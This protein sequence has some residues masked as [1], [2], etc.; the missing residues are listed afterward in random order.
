[1]EDRNFRKKQEGGFALLLTVIVVAVLISIS[2]S[3]LDV[4]IKQV[5]LAGNAKDSEIA[6]QASSAGMECGRH[7]RR[8]LSDEMTTGQTI[9]PSCFDVSTYYSNVDNLRVPSTP[10]ITGNGDVFRY[11]YAFTWGTGLDTRCTEVVTLVASSSP[12]SAVNLV[13]A[14]S[15]MYSI[16]SGWV[17]GDRICEPG[18]QC[19]VLSVRGY[20]KSC[21]NI[22]TYGTVQREVLLQY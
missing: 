10:Q 16:F 20:N 13:V 1:M 21:S 6:F 2:L 11:D 12:S 17:G 8:A 3:I 9:N 15:L 14:E 22:G 4:S 7:I 18:S 19:T 5:R